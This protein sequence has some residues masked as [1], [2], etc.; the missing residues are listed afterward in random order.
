MRLILVRHA[1]TAETGT[2]LSGRLPSIPLSADG[3][4][5]AVARAEELAGL[6]VDV[7]LTSPIQRCRETAR[8]L[9][10]VWDRTARVA[11][12]FTET[13]FGAW[14]GR[15]LTSLHRLKAWQRLMAAPARFEFPDGESFVAV[16]SRAVAAAER[17]AGSHGGQRV[18]VVTHSDVIRVIVGHYAG[19]ALDLVHRLDVRPLSAS[20]IDLPTSGG[21]PRVPVVNSLDPLAGL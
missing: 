15:R 9:G 16:Q 14:S 3:R 8:I 19:A 7:L 5:Q 17:L 2:I 13:D 18:V 6:E 1:P 11:S 12:G 21:A 10:S 20:I 4:D